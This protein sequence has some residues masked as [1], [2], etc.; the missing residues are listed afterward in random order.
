MSIHDLAFEHLPETFKRRSRM[1]LRLTVRRSAR[2][3]ARILS[4]SESVRQDIIETYAI[5][6][7]RV[8]TIPLAAPA[9]FGP[10]HE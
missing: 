3:A 5:A 4:L 9:H 6:P 10:G 7:E 2:K 1:Q 8:T